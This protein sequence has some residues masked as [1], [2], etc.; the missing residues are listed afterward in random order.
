MG[1]K[2]L[3]G[4][5]L[6]RYE[7]R[8]RE[9]R[10]K[11]K[12]KGKVNLPKKVPWGAQNATLFDR[13]SYWLERVGSS[14]A[15]AVRLASKKVPY[16]QNAVALVTMSL[17][18]SKFLVGVLPATL[19]SSG[20]LPTL[21]LSVVLT[22]LLVG[23]TGS[24]LLFL[25]VKSDSNRIRELR[26][27]RS[28]LRDKLIKLNC[29]PIMLR[30]AW[31]DCASFDKSIR[32]WPEC[33]GATGSI[34]FDREVKCP[35][36]S[37]LIKAIDLLQQVKQEFKTVSWADAIQMAGALAVEVTGGPVVEMRYGRMDAPEVEVKAA[38]TAAKRQ[39]APL[40]L[41]LPSAVSPFPDNAP[42]ADV[43]IRNTFYRMGFSNKDIVALCGA[44]TIGRAFKDR[45]GVCPFT[46]GDQGATIY[47]RPTSIAKGD[48]GSGIGM[49][50]GCSWTKNWLQFDNSYFLHTEEADANLLWL[51]TDK[52]LKDCP[53]FKP[54]FI[55]FA[56]D[57]EAF[58]SDY[59]SA[60]KRMS[61]N[62][63]K[64]SPTRGLII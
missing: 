63:A 42:S 25:H 35:A 17:R 27:F 20:S 60:H 33:G 10:G 39:H 8:E 52:A 55:K 2:D 64:F 22:V 29:S 38:S 51:P 36:N 46:S 30:L 1:M 14:A 11:G 21:L 50:G 23:L 32:Q 34:R 48:G 47:T 9:G 31:S 37:G 19:S 58:F 41:R 24:Y 54:H 6:K 43:H 15:V 62:G 28:K 61:E 4:K 26:T 45:S 16:V 7:S 12:G 13:V 3:L 56:K 44:H 59:A 49:P 18:K 57:Q 53:E 5:L 40:S